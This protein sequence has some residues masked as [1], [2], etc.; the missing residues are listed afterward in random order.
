VLAFDNDDLRTPFRR[1]AVFEHGRQV[2]SDKAMPKWL[3]SY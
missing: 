3:R 2:W 1:V